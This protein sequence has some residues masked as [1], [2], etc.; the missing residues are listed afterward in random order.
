LKYW[1]IYAIIKKQTGILQ[2]LTYLTTEIDKTDKSMEVVKKMNKLDLDLRKKEKIPPEMNGSGRAFWRFF[3]SGTTFQALKFLAIYFGVGALFIALKFMA[4]NF[5]EVNETIISAIFIL[6]YG[7]IIYLYF[8]GKTKNY[9]SKIDLASGQKLL[10]GEELQIGQ[11]LEK[12]IGGVNEG[13]WEWDLKTGHYYASIL[14]DE[15]FG[16]EHD[17]VKTVSEWRSLFHKDDEERTHNQVMNYLKEKTDKTYISSYRI[18]TKS[19][20]YRWILSRGKGIWDNEGKALKLIGSHSDIT[21]E[22]YVEE[23]FIREKGICE[24][25]IENA[26]ILIIIRDRDGKIIEF[27]PYA[28]KITGFSKEEVIGKDSFSFIRPK[29]TGKILDE[30]FND[31]VK[32]KI[33]TRNKEIGITNK[34]GFTSTVLWN[35]CFIKNYDGQIIGSVFIGIDVSEKIKMVETL[36]NLAY[37]DQLTK[38]PNKEKLSEIF[39]EEIHHRNGAGKK[40]AVVYFDID[41]LKQINNTLG[42]HAGDE[43]IKR[44]ASLL[45]EEVSP[46]NVVGR[47]SGDEFVIIYVDK[48]DVNDVKKEV[49]RIIKDLRKPMLW[50][51]SEYYISVSSGIA[52]YPQHGNSFSQLIKCA[53]TA[54]FVQK[55]SGKDGVS[56]YDESMGERTWQ[57]MK[58]GN[59][60]KGAINNREFD[61]YLQPQFDIRENIMI[62]AEALIRWVHPQRGVVSPAEFITF[63]EE[64]GFIDKIDQWVIEYACAQIKRIFDMGINNFKVAVNVSG[65]MLSSEKIIGTVK[66]AVNGNGINFSDLEIEV[67]ETAVITNLESAIKTLRELKDLGIKIALDDFGTGYSSLSYLQRLPIDVLKMDRDFIKNVIC[68]DTD[69]YIFKTI[70]DLAHN[71]GL[72]VLAEGVETSQQLEFVKESGC[73]MVQGYLL[74]KPVPCKEFFDLLKIKNIKV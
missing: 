5:F 65:K 64:R 46:P 6:T 56:V 39:E 44:F 58:M 36:H 43:I 10:T 45:E 21:D 48:K 26:P 51:N 61:L 29:E 47:I 37:Y 41:N 66:K 20:Q 50:E 57:V 38:L 28:E 27:N 1:K 53:D 7:F 18:R 31:L 34:E 3:K 71:L 67:T 12:F 17:F 35:N 40:L 33:I 9:L 42:H 2:N 62:G 19:G 54:M 55:E 16:Y 49:T 13:Y 14:N 60:L 74:G 24:K 11:K 32:N 72:L 25:I 73:D 15:K 70:V 68:K 63:A 4:Q 23:L 59:Q 30:Y 69:R 22:M 52:M 8:F